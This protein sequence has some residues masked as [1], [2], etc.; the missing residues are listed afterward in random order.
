[1]FVFELVGKSRLMTSYRFEDHFEYV[2]M[3]HFARF[4]PLGTCLSRGLC[5][6]MHISLVRSD[7]FMHFEG[8][9]AVKNCRR[10]SARLPDKLP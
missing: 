2:W 3:Y 5:N 8:I 6:S 9:N 10:T 1:V 4:H 7:V